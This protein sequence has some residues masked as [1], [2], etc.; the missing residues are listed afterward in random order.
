MDDGGSGIIGNRSGGRFDRCDQMRTPFFT[1]FR[2][3]D[4][5]A[6]PGGRALFAVMR[7]DI[8]RRADIACGGRNVLGRAPTDLA[9]APGVVLDPDLPK[10]CDGGNL[11]QEER[12]CRIIDAME[13]ACPIGPNHCCVGVTCFIARWYPRVLQARIVAFDPFSLTVSQQPVGGHQGQTVQRMAE[14]FSYTQH[15]IERADR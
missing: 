4:L 9:L 5:L 2:Q 15:S 3:M 14:G 8:L 1:G 11:A 13:Q 6:H 10:N 7:L 12:G